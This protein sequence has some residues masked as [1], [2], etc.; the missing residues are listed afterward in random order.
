HV[1][2]LLAI[3]SDPDYAAMVLPSASSRRGPQPTVELCSGLWSPGTSRW[4]WASVYGNVGKGRCASHLS[5]Y[6]QW[7]DHAEVIPE[8]GVVLEGHTTAAVE[9]RPRIEAVVGAALAER[10]AQDGVVAQG[11]GVGVVH[12]PGE[13]RP[14][15]HH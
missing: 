1:T 5:P 11:D 2:S 6:R 14:K 7:A 12:I 4:R 8:Q 13:K 3:V 10:E 9:V 15:A